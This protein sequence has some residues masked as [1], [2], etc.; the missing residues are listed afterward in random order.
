MRVKQAFVM[1]VAFG[2]AALV[3]RGLTFPQGMD[4]DRV[5]FP[6]AASRSPVGRAKI[7]TSSP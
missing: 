7:G 5:R 1:T 2:V 6:T 3:A 4:P